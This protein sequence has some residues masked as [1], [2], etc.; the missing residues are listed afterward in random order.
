QRHRLERL[1][2]EEGRRQKEEQELS[3]FC[4]LPSSFCLRKERITMRPAVVAACLGLALGVGLLGAAAPPPPARSTPPAAPPAAPPAKAAPG[5]PPP[6]RVLAG[7]S[8]DLVLFQESRPYLIRLHLQVQGQSFQA[9]WEGTVRHLFRYL[10]ADGDGTLS[11]KEAAQA[12][13]S[14]QWV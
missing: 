14:G 2:K 12:P 4:L 8:Q 3:S 1:L 6:P 13:S 7:D 11:E 5:R 10:D 9:G